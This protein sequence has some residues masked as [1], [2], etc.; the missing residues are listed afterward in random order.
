MTDNPTAQHAATQLQNAVAAGH[1]AAQH[2]GTAA[3]SGDGAAAA[4]SQPQQSSNSGNG[5]AAAS[6]QPQQSSSGCPDCYVIVY[7]I[8]KH[9][10]V[11]TLLRS[12]TA[13]GVKAVRVVW[14]GCGG[15]ASCRHWPSVVSCVCW[16]RM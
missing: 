6:S 11:G 14:C 3:A 2:A 16:R 13:F 10:N 9:S 12:C 7:N 4:S 8:A 15:H 1:L 5:A